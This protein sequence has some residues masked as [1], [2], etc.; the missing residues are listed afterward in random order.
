MVRSVLGAVVF[1]GGLYTTLFLL[2][3][4]YPYLAGLAII[5]TIYFAGRIDQTGRPQHNKAQ[6]KNNNGEQT[7][8]QSKSTGNNSGGSQHV[9]VSGNRV[10]SNKGGSGNVQSS[11]V[12]S[13][14]S[15]YPPFID[16]L[17]NGKGRH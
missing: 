1:F 2:M 15:E 5:G 16:S 4:P 9:N 11:R 14:R 8:G 6:G 3:S 10:V 17:Y 7:K 12:V 13:P